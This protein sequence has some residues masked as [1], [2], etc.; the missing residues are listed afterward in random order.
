LSGRNPEMPKLKTMAPP[1]ALY[2]VHKAVVRR[3]ERYGAFADFTD[4]PG[5]GLIH[6]SQLSNYRVENVADVLTV[7]DSVYLKLIRIETDGKL[8][9]SMKTVNQRD[10]TDMDPNHVNI[11]LDNKKKKGAVVGSIVTI[12]LD[13]VLNTTCP[14]CGGSGHLKTDCF[15]RLG[16]T[17]Y[18]LIPEPPGERAEALNRALL[19]Q[20]AQEQYRALLK[21]EKKSKKEEKKS[22]KDKKSKKGKKDKKGKKSKN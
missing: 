1:P 6:V 15:N 2:S 9:L 11:M 3:I 10:G 7:G 14:R 20:R 16:D 21:E 13:A 8:S 4:V 17:Q 22:K 19:P 12:E 5:G 18:D